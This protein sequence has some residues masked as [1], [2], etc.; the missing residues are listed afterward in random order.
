MIRSIGW[1]GAAVLFAVPAH[2]GAQ[3]VFHSHQAANLPTAETL[4][5]G[6][7]L[8]EISHRFGRISGED[9]FWG[10]DGPVVNRLGLTYA[11][12]NS[13]QFAV[14]RSN[15]EDNVELNAK[16]ALFEGGPQALPVEIAVMGGVAWNTEVFETEG[17]KDNESQQYAQVILNAMLGGRFGVGVVPTYLRNP[18]ILDTETDNAFVL[19]LNG[20]VY[21]A[22]WA[23][24][25]AEWIVGESRPGQEHDAGTFGVELETR[26]HYFK[27]VL[28]NQ[29]R[30]NSTQ[31]LAGAPVSFEPDEWRMGFNITRLLPF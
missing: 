20:Q 23:S 26:G 7:W 25:L 27:L 11:P 8:F 18:R 22:D 1:V 30:L 5:R 12:T 9:T 21:V 3:A 4:P 10:L 15:Y 13:L 24:F 28:T 16:L 2:A 14:Q 17:A 29:A 6:S 19:G 31:S